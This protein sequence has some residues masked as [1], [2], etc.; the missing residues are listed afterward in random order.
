MGIYINSNLSALKTQGQLTRSSRILNVSFERLSSGRRINHASDD[1]AGLAITNRMEAQVK[2]TVRA[3]HNANDASSLLQTAE[4][5]LSEVTHILQRMRELTVQAGNETLSKAD[6]QSIQAELNQLLEEVDR[7]G[8]V[9]F[10]GQQLFGAHFEFLIGVSYN[11]SATMSLGTNQVA[12]NRLGRHSLIQSKT[13]VDSSR[14]LLDAELTFVKADGTEV[15]IRATVEGDDQWSTHNKAGSA[16]AKAA[17]INAST[18]LHG[19][20]ARA[21]ATTL[22]S[23]G[24]TGKQILD[25]D[26]AIIINQVAISGFTVLEGDA[27][28]T[29]V[30][31]LNAASKQTGVVATLTAEGLISLTAADGRNIAIETLGNG[32]NLGFSHGTVQGGQL[33]LSSRDHYQARFSGVEVNVSTLGGIAQTPPFIEDTGTVDAFFGLYSSGNL[34]PDFDTFQYDAT[35]PGNVAV[36]GTY[37]PSVLGSGTR[38]LVYLSEIFGVTS[39]ILAAETTPNLFSNVIDQV[40]YTGDGNTHT[41]Q[42]DPGGQLGTSVI[43]IALDHTS[44]IDTGFDFAGWS[45]FAF[46]PSS[47]AFEFGVVG[48]FEALMTERFDNSTLASIDVGSTQGVYHAL[49]VLDYAL[50]E[51]SETRAMLGASMNRLESTVSNLSQTQNSLSEAKSRI[52]DADFSAETAT[53]SKTQ[54]IQQAGVSILAQANSA[55]E[56]ALALLR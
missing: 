46:T 42:N 14:A 20:S 40:L 56:L 17:A 25:A 26:D 24:I 43:N 2:G 52:M 16:L 47:G 45:A 44:N 10:N 48:E 3:I 31:A 49:N 28:G 30:D 54:I 33:I 50:E 8:Q 34:D 7:A 11:H 36:N 12:S 9:S 53:L 35:T 15:G 5:T 32:S 37:D 1:A 21:G 4:G 23:E 19:V 55:P 6:R 39:L 38:M 13:G 22:T 18:D 41:F 51:V 27:D 29:L